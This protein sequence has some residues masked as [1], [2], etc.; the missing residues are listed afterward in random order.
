M[1]KLNIFDTLLIDKKNEKFSK[2]LQTKS[3]KIEKIVSNGQKSSDNFWYNQEKNEFVLLLEGR[4]I[5]EI[6]ENEI[7]KEIELK[8][9]DYIDIKANIKHR[10]KYTDEKNPT[11]WL[12][13]FYE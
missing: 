12:A 2:I 9:G 6:K 7:I 5:L 3:I 1:K 10:V 13:I 8:K 11:I 4:A